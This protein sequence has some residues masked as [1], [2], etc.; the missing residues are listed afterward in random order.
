MKAVERGLP[1]A[2]R[3]GGGR[4]GGGGGKELGWRD[5]I[6]FLAGAEAHIIGAIRIGSLDRH[7]VVAGLSGRLLHLCVHEG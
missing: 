2:G 7:I 1:L 4:G 6:L 3:V 5:V